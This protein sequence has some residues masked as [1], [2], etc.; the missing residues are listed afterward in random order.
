MDGTGNASR[1][2]TTPPQKQKG[3]G[4]G[5]AGF[6]LL[7]M[8]VGGG[9]LTWTVF[10][11]PLWLDLG[12]GL[13]KWRWSISVRDVLGSHSSQ[14][15][16]GKHRGTSDPF[17]ALQLCAGTVGHQQ[18]SITCTCSCCNMVRTMELMSQQHLLWFMGIVWLRKESDAQLAWMRDG[19]VACGAAIWGQGECCLQGGVVM[20]TWVGTRDMGDLVLCVFPAFPLA[21]EWQ[22]SSVTGALYPLRPHGLAHG[23]LQKSPSQSLTLLKSSG[24]PRQDGAPCTVKRKAVMFRLEKDKTH[25]IFYI[26]RTAKAPKPSKNPRAGPAARQ[27]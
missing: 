25:L 24:R 8:T 3:G 15:G 22:S 9:K 13:C 20:V 1:F 18:P 4:G 21:N 23:P 5:G 2:F 11:K 10:A 12:P 17:P 6:C 19:M 16:R 14:Q 7:H 27:L 26:F